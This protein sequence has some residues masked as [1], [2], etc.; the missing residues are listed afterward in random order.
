[1]AGNRAAAA[2]IAKSRHAFLATLSPPGAEAD[3]DNGLDAYYGNQCADTEYPSTFLEF[4]LVGA[5]ARAGSRFGPYWWWGNNGCTAWPVNHDR[6]VGPW[7]ARTSAP[8]LVVGNFFDGVTAYTGAQA[9]AK[10]LPNSR[11]LSYAGWGHTAY[12]R[13]AC[14]T[15]YVNAY[16]KNG[17]LPP[18]GTVCPA[19]P[20]P[21]VPPAPSARA[22]T[23][24]QPLVG[25][26]PVWQLHR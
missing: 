7:T 14:T 21:F 18:V 3:Y 20:N 1:V 15:N 26:P 6:Y 13:S 22:A 16:L 4:L 17:A 12:G 19:N 24:A 11:L 9:T 5:Y 23:R 10:L 25:L 8:V 2:A